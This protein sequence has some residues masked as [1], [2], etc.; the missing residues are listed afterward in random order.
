MDKYSQ[1]IVKIIKEQELLMGPVA[2]IEAA[3]VRGLRIDQKNSSISIEG[4]SRSAVDGLVNQYGKLFGRAAR[5]VCKEAVTA[6]VADLSP[7]E[8]PSSLQ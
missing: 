2:W 7:S 1:I 6:L 8:V 4:D 5:E 3:K